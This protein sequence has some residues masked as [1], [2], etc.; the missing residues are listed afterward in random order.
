MCS[1]RIERYSTPKTC[2]RNHAVV[3][4][5]GVTPEPRCSQ[6]C[7]FLGRSSRL[8]PQGATERYTKTAAMLS[9]VT[10]RFRRNTWFGVLPP[11]THTIPTLHGHPKPV[12]VPSVSTGPVRAYPRCPQA[13]SE[14]PCRSPARFS[15]VPH[16]CVCT[17]TLASSKLRELHRQHENGLLVRCQA[18]Y[19]GGSP[20]VL[21]L[22]AERWPAFM[23]HMGTVAFGNR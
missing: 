18:T 11:L 19:R 9:Y 22:A 12:F 2:S 23:C 13:Q 14:R 16:Y 6:D 4:Y 8:E 20:Q 15:T 21:F 5:A 10:C 17:A 7:G 1:K 3:C